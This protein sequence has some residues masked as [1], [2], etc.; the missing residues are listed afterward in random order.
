[1]YTILFVLIKNILKTYAEGLGLAK[2]CSYIYRVNGVRVNHILIK[3]KGYV[4]KF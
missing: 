3:N 2:N 1:L 4:E